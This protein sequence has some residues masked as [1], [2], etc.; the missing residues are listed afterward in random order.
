MV[1]RFRALPGL[2]TQEML[3][4]LV[5]H[6]DLFEADQ[7]KAAQCLK[8]V[9]RQIQDTEAQHQ[10][11]LCILTVRVQ[12]TT[13]P[14]QRERAQ[15]HST[16]LASHRSAKKLGRNLRKNARLASVLK[17]AILS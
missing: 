9:E 12:P 4:E 15:F 10:A 7:E 11:L 2:N 3:M 5:L 6:D 14:S 8:A 1:A 17:V 16:M 13:K